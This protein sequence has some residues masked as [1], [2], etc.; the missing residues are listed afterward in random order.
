MEEVIAIRE[1]VLDYSFI[2][3]P[4]GDAAPTP[5]EGYQVQLVIQDLEGKDFYMQFKTSERDHNC[6]T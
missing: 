2:N 3:V 1:T 4:T 5:A 6:P